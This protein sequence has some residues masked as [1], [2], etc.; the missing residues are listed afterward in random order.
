M[1]QLGH[2]AD[3]LEKINTQL[4]RIAN[5]LESMQKKRKL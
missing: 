1:I 4:E 2:I 5:A 3:Q